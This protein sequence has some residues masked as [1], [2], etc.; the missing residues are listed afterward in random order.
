MRL[1]PIASFTNEALKAWAAQNLAP[2]AHVVS[3]GLLCFKQVT[4]VAAAHERHMTGSGRQAAKRPEFRWVRT[5]LGNLKT[6]LAGTCHSFDHAK[7]AARYLAESAYRF[8]RRFDLAA[9]LPRLLHAAVV[10]KP[11]PLLVSRWPEAGI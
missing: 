8:N 5:M 4:Q 1:T 9:M 3:D 7:Y 11:Q 2:T 6:A 10:T